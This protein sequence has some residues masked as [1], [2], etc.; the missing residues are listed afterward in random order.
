MD[1]ISVLRFLLG[2]AFLSAASYQDLKEREVNALIFLL[3]GLAAFPILLYEFSVDIGVLI[4]VSIFIISFFE[5][6]KSEHILNA[7]FLIMLILYIT[8][9]GNRIIFADGILLI[10]YRYLFIAG[11]MKGGADMRA[12]MAITLLVPHYPETFTGFDVNSAISY[13]FPYSLEV[14]F[15]AAV[16]NVL[17]YVPYLLFRNIKEGN[18][19]FPN[20]LTK[21][22]SDGKWIPYQTPFVFTIT[23]AFIFSFLFSLFYIL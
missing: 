8:F 15:Y 22:Y 7:I 12:I 11:I 14:L 21:L 10:F 23:I 2:F 17:I 9:N 4:I 19:S 16:L 13:I 5:L 3:M 6:G 18:I 1:L 20:M